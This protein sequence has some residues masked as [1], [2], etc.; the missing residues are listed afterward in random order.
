M[1][2]LSNYVKLGYTWV[3]RTG[4]LTCCTKNSRSK[5]PRV[6]KFG[7]S[8]LRRR[9]SFLANDIRLGLSPPKF[10]DSCCMNIN[11]DREREVDVCRKL[12]SSSGFSFDTC[13]SSWSGVLH[14]LAVGGGAG[15][16]RCIIL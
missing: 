7:G 5:N 16:V 4:R 1:Q 3:L 15:G 6:E 13:D 10:P 12:L 14:E 2:D 9:N 8:P 11:G